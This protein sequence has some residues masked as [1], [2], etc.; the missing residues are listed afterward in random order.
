MFLATFLLSTGLGIVVIAVSAALAILVVCHR[1]FLGFETTETPSKTFSNGFC[2]VETFSLKPCSVV[3]H[4]FSNLMFNQAKKD[5]LLLAFETMDPFGF[6]A[7]V[8]IGTKG[9][10][11]LTLQKLHVAPIAPVHV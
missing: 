9:P 3:R 5:G 7:V 6:A 4:V 8:L 1:I 10:F 2:V 11:R